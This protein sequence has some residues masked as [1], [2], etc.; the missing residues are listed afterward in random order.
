LLNEVS[1]MVDAGTLRTTLTNTAGKIDAATLRAVHAAVESG[2]S[3]G[4]T[5]LAGF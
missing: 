4:K 1:A 5:V 2:R 3:I